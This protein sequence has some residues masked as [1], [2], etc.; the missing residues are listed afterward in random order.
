MRKNS[1][2]FKTYFTSEA[3][4]Y[5]VNKDYFAFI[6]LDD[7]AC[8]L[9]ADGIDSD[10]ELQSA[11][12]AA[13]SIFEDFYK[14]PTISRRKIKKYL[15]H[16]HEVLIEQSRI[17]RLKSSII[18]V[19]TNYS[20]VVWAVAGNT[21][22]YYFREGNLKF[23][24]NDQSVAQIMASSGKIDINEIDRHEEKNN[25]TNYLGKPNNFKPYVSFKRKLMDGDIMLLCS[26][27]FCQSIK[28]YQIP[29]SLKDSKEPDE[30]VDKL[31]DMLLTNQR[32]IINN[33]TMGAVFV[34]KT[35]KENNKD[36]ISLAKKIGLATL[37]V[38]VVVGIVVYLKVSDNKKQAAIRAN[39]IKYENEGDQD[40]KD[41]NFD[42]ALQDYQKSDDYAKQLKK[43]D[44]QNELDQKSKITECVSD[45]DKSY[46]SKDYSGAEKTYEKALKMASKQ[47]GYDETEI[48]NKIQE[49]ELCLN[50][51][52]LEKQGD[53]QI[54][55]Q[56]Y[57]DAKDS[58]NKAK[59][60]A[61]QIPMQDVEKDIDSKLT[62]LN[63]KITDLNNKQQQLQGSELEKQ[64]DDSFTAQ[65]YS[66]AL[67]C[68]Q[69]AQSIYQQLN[70]MQGVLSIQ[71]KIENAQKMLTPTVPASNTGA[72][73]TPPA[74]GSA[75]PTNQA[76][77][78][79]QTAA[80]T[81]TQQPAAST[82]K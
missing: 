36:K 32:K 59:N 63:S 5:A 37:A 67:S 70:D 19:V 6:E 57:D 13:R 45:G 27:G 33:Y 8:Y 79:A 58:Y 47:K 41:G 50:V 51:L 20:R 72:Q 26:S 75:T 54:N 22:L 31:E 12:I 11:E 77:P 55:N 73:S 65:N 14:K 38:I 7:Y 4:T 34:N 81:T 25:L 80:P 48:K 18:M 71:S 43:N 17:V 10:D 76:P 62:D 24:S 40:V 2:D 82:G 3:G 1:S 66:K 39:A 35:F 52:D 56:K 49:T 21:R 60:L 28:P 68:Y 16:A 61:A 64:G 23:T 29:L 74:Q 46:Q 9:V 53:D 78:T 44:M 42:I 30:F 15:N 69:T